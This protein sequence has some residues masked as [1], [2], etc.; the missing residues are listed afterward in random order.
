MNIEVNYPSTPGTVLGMWPSAVAVT[1]SMHAP[2]RF[3][4]QDALEFYRVNEAAHGILWLDAGTTAVY[5][6]FPE[7]YQ[8][9]LAPDF[10]ITER[11]DFE[12][13]GLWTIPDAP[14]DDDDEGGGS[15]VPAAPLPSAGHPSGAR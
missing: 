10:R 5:R 11:G 7:S 15:G 3:N 6:L 2:M 13:V 4:H 12:L 9:H 1:N 14:P 8:S